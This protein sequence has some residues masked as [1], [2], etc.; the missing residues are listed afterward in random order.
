SASSRVRRL[1]PRGS[2]TPRTRRPR[3]SRRHRQGSLGRSPCAHT[4]KTRAQDKAETDKRAA[5]NKTLV[6]VNDYV[7][8]AAKAGALAAVA[9]TTA[10]AGGV[11][12]LAKYAVGYRGM[13]QLNALTA[14]AGYNFRRLF[15]GVDPSPLVRAWDK[16][17]SL[18]NPNS[19]LGAGLS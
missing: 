16:V 11:A 3:G 8:K 19:F 5:V 1:R 12:F 9:L 7:Q 2:R 14:R 4:R 6:T 10:A 13:Y 15:A 17:T 18:V